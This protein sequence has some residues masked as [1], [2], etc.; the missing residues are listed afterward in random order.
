VLRRGRVVARRARG[1]AT[2]DELA[3][4]MI[5][6]L[7]PPFKA[8]PAAARADAAVPAANNLLEISGLVVERDGWRALD[9]VNLSVAAGEIVGI[10]GVDG[11]GQSE[12]I[13]A[14]AGVRRPAG[15]SIR[16]TRTAGA[17]DRGRDAGAIAVIPENRDLDGLILEMPLWENLM[18]A[19]PLLAR[20]C[21]GRRGWLRASRAIALCAELLERFRIRAAGPRAPAAALS[22]GN[23]QRLCV[24]RALA[25]RPRVL[26]AHNVTRGLDLA[27]TAE[28]HRMLAAFAAEGGAV[29]LVSS[30]L[31]ELIALCGRLCVIS[32][33]RV[34][35]VDAGERDPARLG[36]LMAGAG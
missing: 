21:G 5:G 7:A 29:L 1:E 32:R 36:L 19:R 8:G 28:V 33:G 30:D 26:A 34:R 13:E 25:S 18:L 2:E 24:A 11:N 10:A 17:E 3:V 12:L 20:A 35:A 4:L 9:D 31:D 22:G 15:G 27:A 14:M 16:V 6:E 23:R